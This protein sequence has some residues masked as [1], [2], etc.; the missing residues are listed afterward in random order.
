[1]N[2]R[3]FLPGWIQFHWKTT[4][5]LKCK[6]QVIPCRYPLTR[7]TCS[8]ERP[9]SAKNQTWKGQSCHLDAAPLL[10]SVSRNEDVGTQEKGPKDSQEVV[11]GV[12]EKAPTLKCSSPGWAAPRRL[13]SH[14]PRAGGQDP[15]WW[16]WGEEA[17]SCV[18]SCCSG[19]ELHKHAEKQGSCS[20]E[21]LGMFY[22]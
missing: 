8:L 4:E 19:W 14:R 5:S 10:S 9:H 1:M 6:C 15:C 18:S 20:Q 13:V 16:R 17:H 12:S 22:T 2:R 7:T 3:G 21:V 11:W